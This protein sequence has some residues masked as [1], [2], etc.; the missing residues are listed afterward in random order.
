[1]TIPTVDIPLNQSVCMC[2][3]LKAAAEL[4]VVNT[5]A[6]DCA[7]NSNCDGIECK[8]RIFTDYFIEVEWQRCDDPTGVLIAL[9]LYNGALLTEDYFNGSVNA[10]V[11]SYDIPMYVT[12]MNTDYSSSL[13]VSDANT[14]TM[15]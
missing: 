11:S 8:F 6:T 15:N 12:M 10:N 13:E 3:S 4:N 7:V 9:R 14:A 5:I 1:M 2:M